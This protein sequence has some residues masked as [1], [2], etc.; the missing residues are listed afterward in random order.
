LVRHLAG[1]ISEKQK[2]R[3][4][5][6]QTCPQK[7]D[8]EETLIKRMLQMG[9]EAVKHGSGWTELAQIVREKK[10]GGKK[11]EQPGLRPKQKL[12]VPSR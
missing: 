4:I 1:E 6:V 11:T 5:P 9:N 10:K 8:A 7:E 3:V 2:E 12:W